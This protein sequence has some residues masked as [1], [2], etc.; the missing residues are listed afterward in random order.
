MCMRKAST[1][2][3]H[4]SE[5]AIFVVKLFSRH[6]H[7]I[8]FVLH[9][10]YLPFDAHILIWDSKKVHVLSCINT[11]V[12]NYHCLV[13]IF[14]LPISEYKLEICYYF[15]C[16]YLSIVMTNFI[17]YNSELRFPIAL[18]FKSFDRLRQVLVYLLDVMWRQQTI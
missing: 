6:M 10:W 2:A 11:S 9:Q 18:T 3:A 14:L 16:S 8:C 17:T 1:T 4:A 5:K 12:K 7:C 15:L 13:V